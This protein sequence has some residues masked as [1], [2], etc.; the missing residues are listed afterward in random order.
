[1]W[2]LKI[3]EGIKQNRNRFTV[4]ENKLVVTRREREEGRGKMGYGV[5]RHKLL[6]IK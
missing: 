6:C 1:M 4:I 5:K 2:D 3:N